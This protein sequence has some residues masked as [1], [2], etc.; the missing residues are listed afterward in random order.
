MARI[1]AGDEAAFRVVADRHVGRMLRVAQ[2]ILGSAADADEITQEALLRVWTQAGKWDPERARLSTWIHMIVTRL[3]IDRLRRRRD[4][5]LHEAPEPED[6]ALG[7]FD[8]LAR[9]SELRQLAVA[10]DRLPPRQRAALVL[11]CYEE[12]EG[13]EAAAMLGVSLRAFWSLLQRAR[14]SVQQQMRIT[15]TTPNPGG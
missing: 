5:P 4:V 9:A 1:A 11:F 6:P 2:K 3:S 14:R 7:P 15:S 10:M 8:A 13:A 12:T